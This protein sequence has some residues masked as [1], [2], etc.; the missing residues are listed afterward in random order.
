MA[1]SLLLCNSTFFCTD[2]PTP[3][4]AHFVDIAAQGQLYFTHTSGAGGHYYLIETM[5]A[6]AA[7][8]DYDGD[9]LLD[10]YLVDGFDLA[11]VDPGHQPIN[12]VQR[13]PGAYRV[14]EEYRQALRFNGQVDST[15]Y[16]VVQ[17]A[18]NPS[19]GNGLYRN[20]AD[21]T[22]SQV[23]QANGAP[24]PGYG[25]GVAV[26]DY[27]NDGDPDIYVTNY[28]PN[29]LYRN[30]LGTFSNIS[31]KAGIDVPH[32]SS[33]AAFFDYDNDG[34]LD[35]FTV[36]YLDFTV[37]NNRL[38]GSITGM[39]DGLVTVPEANRTYCSPKRYNGAPDILYRN[40]GDDTFTDI[41]RQAGLFQIFGKG[42]GVSG[43]DID[44]DGDIDLY[45]ANDGIRNYLYRRDPGPGFT[46]IGLDAGVA[47][48]SAGGPES[49][50]GTGLGDY[51]GD[52]D[53]D[54]FVTNFSDETNT[55]YRNDG[56]A[57]FTDVTDQTGLGQPSLPYLGFG[58]VLFDGDNDGDLDLYVANGHVED[59]AHL[60]DQR[61]TYA[62]TD[63]YFENTATGAF[64][65]ASAS[66][67]PALAQKYVTRGVAKGDYDNDG[68]IDLLLTNSNGPA[69]LLRNDLPPANHWLTLKLVGTADNRDA[70]GAVVRLTCDERVLTRSI[71]A[72]GSYLTASD[73]RLHFGLGPCAAI[74]QVD[75]RWPNG[76]R[77]Q[78]GPM[79]T[80]Q[81]LLIEQERD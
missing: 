36:N 78:L 4:K 61:L 14:V 28:G 74:D 69:Q 32:W 77:Q 59:K 70:V 3:V 50:M 66:S 22:F 20:R 49:G 51:D 26:G 37:A 52:G 43:G 53:P 13:V 10:I 79:A 57:T 54:L 76:T 75:I 9:G 25:M 47:Y 24:D 27:D 19:R 42:L 72:G 41:T 67:G 68:D 45:V 5:G 1:V 56:R 11:H 33:S 7:F 15:V 6:G 55:L 63:Q 17:T 39:G 73:T 16:R 23:P 65:D 31:E 44:D 71:V 64:A 48:N 34:D 60:R 62:Q 21:G 2:P 81:F 29:A 80:R 38:C 30:D 58:T 12:L 8:L 46:D 35:L 18:A 40:D